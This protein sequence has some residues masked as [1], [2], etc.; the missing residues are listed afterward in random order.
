MLTYTLIVS[1]SL[2]TLSLASFGAC[3]EECKGKAT[4]GMVLPFDP[5]TMT[6][7]DLHYYVPIP[8]V[9]TRPSHTPPPL[10]SS[11]PL[12]HVNSRLTPHVVV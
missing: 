12:A 7:R 6:F 1:I 5:L 10:F 4:S 8:K 2:C 9:C 11:A 3:R